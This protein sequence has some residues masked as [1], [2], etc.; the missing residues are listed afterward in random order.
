M[1]GRDAACVNEHILCCRSEVFVAQCASKLHCAKDSLCITWTRNS[2]KGEVEEF[3]RQK[4]GTA[5]SNQGWK[6]V[7][8][9]SY[10]S[11]QCANER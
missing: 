8:D 5:L 1:L 9:I 6:Q 3:R 10:I 4:N 11:I 7:N 2:N